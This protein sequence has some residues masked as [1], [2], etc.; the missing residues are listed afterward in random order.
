MSFEFYSKK[1][2]AEAQRA[3]KRELGGRNEEW[4]VNPHSSFS[5]KR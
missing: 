1:F 5:S 3:Q 4:E 2:H